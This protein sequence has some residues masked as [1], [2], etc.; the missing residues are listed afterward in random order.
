VSFEQMCAEPTFRDF[1]CM[2]IGE[3]YKRS[4]HTVSICNS[5][6][7][8]VVLSARWLRAA[9]DKG[10][11]GAIQFHAD[12]DLEPLPPFWGEALDVDADMIR[13]QR[14]SNSGQIARR[15]WR[16]RYGVMTVSVNDTLLRARMQAWMDGVRRSWE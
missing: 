12:Q 7:A 11:R 4:R 8:V 13:L 3:G 1:I 2:Y 6:P 10:L 5:D 14:K 9:S 15:Q 16:S